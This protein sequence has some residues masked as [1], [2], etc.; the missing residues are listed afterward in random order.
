MTLNEYL[1]HKKISQ[2]SFATIVGV[3]Q[4][5]I[6]QVI[7]GKY[8]PKGCKAIEWSRA[9]EWLVTPHELN[10]DDYPNVTDGL[11]KTNS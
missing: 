6:S 2:T 11:P 7:A 10:S 5:F 1:L 9:T 3:S 8:K 4:G